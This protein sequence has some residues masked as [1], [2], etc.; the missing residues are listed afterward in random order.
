MSQTNVFVLCAFLC[1]G[2]VWCVIEEPMCKATEVAMLEKLVRLENELKLALKKVDE[3][4]TNIQQP[5]LSV[6]RFVVATRCCFLNCILRQ[7][8]IF[9][10]LFFL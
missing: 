10:V 6:T 7:V 8:R 4:V 5:S 3:T 2:T 9:W 1:L